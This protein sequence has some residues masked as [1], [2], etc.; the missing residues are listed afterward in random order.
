MSPEKFTTKKLDSFSD[1]PNIASTETL[2][3][4]RETFSPDIL[5]NFP[6]TDPTIVY[7]PMFFLPGWPYSG[8]LEPVKPKPKYVFCVFGVFWVVF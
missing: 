5:E 7:P 8:Q 2:Q 6:Y 3:K 1:S 4:I